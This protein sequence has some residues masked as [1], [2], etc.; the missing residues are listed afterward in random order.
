MFN[1]SDIHIILASASASRAELLRKAGLKFEIKPAD[2][3]EKVIRHVMG[4]N[5]DS[6]DP[7]DVAEILART[8]AETVSTAHPRAFVI[9]ADQVLS[10]D[11]K[12]FEKPPDLETARKNLF[13]L[14]DRTHHLHSAV[15][16]ALDGDV[17]WHHN[18]SA[19]LTM[20]NFSPEF[21]GQYIAEAGPEIC[22][23][24]GAYL[25][26]AQGIHLFSEIDGDHFAILGL[27]LI[28]LLN[29]FRK[30]EIIKS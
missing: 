20:R 2:I 11:G 29:F 26:E 9:G 4:L 1:R 25:L 6:I 13:E 28:S 5:E 21:L 14:R 3:D 10:A 30:R 12:I 15:C 23:S 27:P 16:V 18:E 7:I 19:S 8:K 17:V 22:N 24:V